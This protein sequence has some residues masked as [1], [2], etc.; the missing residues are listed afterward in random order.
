VVDLDA[1]VGDGRFDVSLPTPAARALEPTPQPL[2]E[3]LF[4]LT[5]D[6][7]AT[8][9]AAADRLGRSP[10]APF[11]VE[12]LIAL[13]DDE[14]R[15]VR[16]AAISALAENGDARAVRPLKALMKKSGSLA[17]EAGRALGQLERRLAGRGHDARNPDASQAMLTARKIR[18]AT[19]ARKLR[20]RSEVRKGVRL[21]LASLFLWGAG[22]AC[23]GFGVAVGGAAL[24]IVAGIAFGLLGF[25]VM[26][27]A[28]RY[29]PA[30]GL[31]EYV[32]CCDPDLSQSWAVGV[33]LG[34]DLDGGGGFD[35]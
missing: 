1:A 11:L 27:Y 8:R 23:F 10:H 4:R 14:R 29:M 15:E 19:A 22:V 31:Q 12:P 16:R 30:E 33:A 5:V 17:E 35:G 13:L 20:L 25:A 18:E 34:G 2:Q 28:D 9:C 6:K 7:S 26:E 32:A 3:L 24:A 21:K